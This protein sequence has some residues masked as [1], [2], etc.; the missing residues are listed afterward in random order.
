VKNLERLK[1]QNVRSSEPKKPLSVL[2]LENLR[3]VAGG[4]A[5][6]HAFGHSICISNE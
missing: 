4:G 1:K 3:Q 2:S 6:A 5:Y